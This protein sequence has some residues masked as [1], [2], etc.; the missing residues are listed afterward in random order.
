MGELHSSSQPAQDEEELS[1]AIR[2]AIA[3]LR[4]KFAGQT[5]SVLHWNANYVAVPL[6]VDVEL[7]SRG[8]V[9]GVDIRRR[10][11]IVLLFSRKS[12]PYLAP[13]VYSDRTD[14]P[15]TAFPHVNITAPGTP[16]WLCLHRGSI[17][18]WFA[19]HTVV[20]L[21]ERARGWFR[22]AARNR[23]VPEG[24]GFEPTRAVETLGT[25]YYPP[26]SN[27]E[28]ILFHWK[29]NGGA[30]GHVVTSF[31]LLDDESM[32]EIGATGYAVRQDAFVAPESYADQKSLAV[33]INVLQEKP[34]FKSFLQRRLFGLLVWAEEGVV[35]RKHFGE[36]PQT[37][38]ELETWAQDLGLPLTQALADYLS[39]D[40]QIM[41]GVPIVLA[42]RRPQQVLGTESDV[43]LLNFLVSAGGGHWP[44]DGR[45]DPA[46][47]VFLS[48]H[49]TPLTPDFARQISALPA[50]GVA[51]PTVV[52]GA[53]A[54]GSK[55]TTHLAR[56]GSVALK[57]VDNAKIAPHNLVRHALGGRAIGLAK[58]EAL[59]DDLVKL[60]PG[61]RDLPIEAVKG[62]ALSRLRNAD[63]FDG[64]SN[65]I[66]MTAS[67]I[68]FNALR[69]A[70]LPATVR[71]HRAE[72]A[73]R[74][75]LGLLS[76]E[77]AGRNP[78][79]DDLQTLIYDSAIEDDAVA[80]WLGEVKATRD[81]R[82]GSGGLEDI[83][84]GLSCSS[85]TMRLADE[86]VSFHAAA[87][88]R[89]LRPYLA[90]EGPSRTDGAVYRSFLGDDGDSKASTRS[91]APTVVL[92]ADSGWQIRIA[93][94]VAETMSMLT[95]KHS[96]SETGG[97]LVGRIAAPR[98]TIFVTRLVPAPPDS[99]GTPW[100][101]TRGTEKLPEALEHI[102]R[103]TGGLLTYVGEWHTHPMGGSDLS[104]T[105]KG[106]VISLRSILDNV[107]L[108]T[109][110][111]IVTPD[112]IKPHLFEPTSPPIIVDPPRRR[113]GIIRVILGWR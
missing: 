85:A 74:G 39:H 28:R 95:R 87:V 24:D 59:K 48:D 67:N 6:T 42:I 84:I 58:A 104:D 64:Y 7:P 15:K 60:Y 29:A 10:E 34:E 22:D 108:P 55:V 76:I 61:Q 102:G 52:F 4:A 37:L 71:V 73:H 109:L 41:A 98:K 2:S 92:D 80:A 96:P 40:L 93:A 63:F 86:V 68:V 27:L 50:D 57:I 11:P 51:R 105:D 70:D 112:E 16:A 91:F 53:G 101:F 81:D 88:T 72:I 90:K 23:L 75:K 106:A 107:G 103:R 13:Y 14:F 69:D 3:E 65:L 78:R 62:S 17:D 26:G 9:A 31:D 19:E 30:A 43:E 111:T 25:F 45:W 89:R 47:T 56:S 99:R 110:V 36:L 83:Q 20:D 5:V 100:V 113:F 46:A 77:G 32:A 54:L 21:V 35:S 18:T 49:R 1:P 97:I 79:I 33:A 12:F 38:G 82:V 94:G 8:P 66:D 44:T